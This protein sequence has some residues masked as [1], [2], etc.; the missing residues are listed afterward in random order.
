MMYGNM[1]S[2]LFLYITCYLPGKT[3]IRGLGGALGRVD[4]FDSNEVIIPR[5]SKLW[6]A[7]FLGTYT[8][9]VPT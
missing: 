7:F 5:L 4:L 2:S 8:V 3:S 1:P 6:P 9:I